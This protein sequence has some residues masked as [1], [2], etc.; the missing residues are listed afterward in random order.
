M[1]IALIPLLLGGAIAL[2]SARLA[3]DQAGEQEARAQSGANSAKDAH[4]G[5]F[6]AVLA[7]VRPPQYFRPYEWVFPQA[8]SEVSVAKLAGPSKQWWVT[9]G[10]KLPRDR[11]NAIW[12]ELEAR[13]RELGGVL[14]TQTAVGQQVKSATKHLVSLVG[15]RRGKVRVVDIRARV[16]ETSPR[17]N[18]TLLEYPSQGMEG[19]EKVSIDL[20]DPSGQLTATTADGAIR[21]LL[22]TKAIAL[23]E[24]EEVGLE[25]TAG[26]G[27]RSYR[28]EL[29]LTIDHDIT[30]RETVRIRA[31]G[32]TDGPAFHTP[33]WGYH[34]TFAGGVYE[35]DYYTYALIRKR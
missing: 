33:A 7:R 13:K 28:W 24:G 4:L 2:Y 16:L 3:L 29:E 5:R 10:E 20:D 1:S 23:D 32:T 12:A 17:M 9:E 8:L 15:N 26:A 22:D 11:V 6:P 18:G 19:I 31:D 35:Q 27:A 30:T 14:C 34:D 25:I 21:P